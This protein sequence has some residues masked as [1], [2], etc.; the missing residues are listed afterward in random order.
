[1]CLCGEDRVQGEGGPV[2]RG[3]GGG[4]R[5]AENLHFESLNSL[6]VC[7]VESSMLE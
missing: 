4:V 5:G 6:G 3:G 1:M 7:I 2:Q